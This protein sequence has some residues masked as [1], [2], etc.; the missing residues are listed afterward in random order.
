MLEID[1]QVTSQTSATSNTTFSA[2]PPSTEANAS[3]TES[4]APK[5]NGNRNKKA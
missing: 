4:A 2:D 1:G 5:A 3:S